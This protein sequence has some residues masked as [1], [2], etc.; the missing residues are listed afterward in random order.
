MIIIIKYCPL[1]I[2]FAV[3]PPDYATATQL[4]APSVQ[5]GVH[6]RNLPQTPPPPYVEIEPPSL[7]ATRGAVP[8]PPSAAPSHS[9][10]VGN[11]PTH[12]AFQSHTAM[13]VSGP[14][15]LGAH[16][17]QAEGAAAYSSSSSS[18]A[19]EAS[20]STVAGSSGVGLS[21][22]SND[23]VVVAAPSG[24]ATNLAG[25]PLL[26][27]NQ[28]Q[29][30]RATG[31]IYRSSRGPDAGVVPNRRQDVPNVFVVQPAEAGSAA[32]ATTLSSSSSLRRPPL[33][34]SSTK[35][36]EGDYS[37]GRGSPTTTI[38]TSHHGL[39]APDVPLRPAEP[40]SSFSGAGGGGAGAARDGGEDS[41]PGARGPRFASDRGSAREGGSQTQATHVASSGGG[42]SRGAGGASQGLRPETSSG[43]VEDVDH[44]YLV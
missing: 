6:N 3:E 42:H 38:T 5:P 18:T 22:R 1:Y 27:L 28:P 29:Q 21:A 44:L 12:L 30:G 11:N 17:T 32:T 39:S 8:P 14:A 36:R 4:R 9:P 13:A 20:S 41:R 35:N 10:R 40:S 2:Y 31:Q 16:R 33:P 25:A 34:T 24:A 15:V 37:A 26:L 43:S 23:S 19:S 7:A